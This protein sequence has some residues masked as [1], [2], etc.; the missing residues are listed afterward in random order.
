MTGLDDWQERAIKMATA[1]TEK[2][3]PELMAIVENAVRQYGPLPIHDEETAMRFARALN[4]VQEDSF[5]LG[6]KLGMQI[7]MNALR[8]KPKESEASKQ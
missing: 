6:M 8:D 4:K 1:M 3:Q 7:V 2:A 5:E